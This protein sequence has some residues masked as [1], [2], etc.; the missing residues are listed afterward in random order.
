MK[1]ENAEREIPGGDA[2]A[3]ARASASSW[4]VL[5]LAHGSPERIEE[6]PE[7]LLNVRGGRP[8]PEPAV[9]EIVRRYELIGGGSPLRRWTE[10]QAQ[11]LEARLGVPVLY[12]MR[13][14]K[15]YIAEAVAAL[16][17]VER[18]VVICL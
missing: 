10:A 16:P 12:G 15:P 7:Y 1:G 13:N 2:L 6:I 9:R 11:M 17:A 3:D 8:L 14:W 5:L 4:A 18:L